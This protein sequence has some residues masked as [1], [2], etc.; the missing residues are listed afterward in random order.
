MLKNMLKK[1]LSLYSRFFGVCSV[2][3]FYP[4]G[5][6]CP[7]ETASPAGNIVPAERC[8]LVWLFV[9]LCAHPAVTIHSVEAICPVW[10]IYSLKTFD[11]LGREQQSFLLRWKDKVNLQ[12]QALQ[13]E[14]PC[15]MKEQMRL[16]VLNIN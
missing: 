11:S 4:V 15:L 16:V 1:S 7:D 3:T 9:I 13:L 8:H 12:T 5:S 2:R 6:F 10:T 14:W